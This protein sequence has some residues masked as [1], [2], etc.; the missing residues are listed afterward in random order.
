LVREARLHH[1]RNPALPFAAA[2]GLLA[3][4]IVAA[5]ARM[6]VDDAKG[7]RLL[8]QIKQDAHEHDVLEDVGE[9]AGVEGMAVVHGESASTKADATSFY[10]VKPGHDGKK[11]IPRAP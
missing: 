2:L 5:R 11:S 3:G 4:E 9:T 6:G 7:G 1:P 10:F 8:L